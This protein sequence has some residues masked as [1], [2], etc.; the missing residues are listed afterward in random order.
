MIM[1]NYDFGWR[2]FVGLLIISA[3]VVGGVILLFEHLENPTDA[4]I[5]LIL[6]PFLLI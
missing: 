2:D 5:A 4:A 3:V 1:N 6:L